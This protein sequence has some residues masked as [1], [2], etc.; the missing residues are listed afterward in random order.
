MIEDVYEPLGAYRDEFKEK[1]ARLSREKFKALTEESGVD[2]AANRKQ[3]AVV[4]KLQGELGDAQGKRTLYG[5]LMALGFLAALA[6]FGLLIAGEGLTDDGKLASSIAGI[7]GVLFGIWM[8]MLF[9]GAGDLVREL[10][11]KVEE[12]KRKAWEQLAAL[13]GLY[14]W[15]ITVKLIEKT[16]PRLAFDSFFTARRLEDLRRLYGW[17]DSFNDGKSIV[18]AQSGVINGNPFLIGEYRE[19]EWGEETYEGTKT[20]CWTEWERGA[21]GK[22][23]AVTRTETLHAYVTKPKPVYSKSK[24]LVYGNDAA[25][26]LKFSHQPS[27]FDDDDLFDGLRKRWRLS[28]LKAFSRNLTDDSSFTLMSNHEFETWFNAKDRDNEVEFRLLF[29]AL[30]QTQMLEL[31]KDRTVGFGDDFVFLKDRK[32]NYLMPRHLMEATIDTAPERFRHWDYDQAAA[33]FHEFNEKYFRDV[34]F[35]LA[36]ILAIPLYQQTRTHEDIWKGVTGGE[37]SSFW[38]HESMANYY[39]DERFKHPQCITQNILKTKLINRVDG[40]SEVRVTAHGYRGV[41]HVEHERVHGGDGKWH[42]V[43]VEWIE[44]LPVE[45][46]TEMYVSESASPG[47]DFEAKY[48]HSRASIFRRSIYSYLLD[49]K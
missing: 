41:E 43:P 30:A 42:T 36:P 39:G 21:D 46:T 3:G 31:M 20:I 23:H 17:N 47:G 44:Y 2:V 10:E 32:L 25:P 15:D 1:F 16:V 11:A 28:R 9:N 37:S 14:T 4:K 13:N 5:T 38:E 26:N 33:N 22:R 12:E 6:G 35:A 8:A 19:M 40:G 24:V 29:T 27:G 7:G 34:Y 18:F 45:K 48:Q 49:Q